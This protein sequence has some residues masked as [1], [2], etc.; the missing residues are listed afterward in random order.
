MGLTPAADIV[1]EEQFPVEGEAVT[2][3]REDVFGVPEAV[4]GARGVLRKTDVVEVGSISLQIFLR[5]T[6]L[7]HV[8]M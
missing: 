7:I 6:H 5:H 2:A 8:H 1:G 3:L 4:H